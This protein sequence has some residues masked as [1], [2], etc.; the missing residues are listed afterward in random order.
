LK[1]RALPLLL[2]FVTIFIAGCNANVYLEHFVPKDADEF[3]REYIEAI[4]DGDFDAARTAINP[5]FV[6]P[7]I[8]ERFK[9]VREKFGGA[10][11]VSMKLVKF[12]NTYNF[13]NGTDIISSF[14]LYEIRTG[15][16]WFKADVVV[17]RGTERLYI[18]GF[19][20]EPMAGPFK[21]I[22]AFRLS[23]KSFYQYTLIPIS[24][25][26]FIFIIHTALLCLRVMKGEDMKWP[27]F[28]FILFGAGA[29]SM[30]WTTGELAWQLFT[31]QFLGSGIL[32]DGIHGPWI[33]STSMPVGAIFFYFKHSSWSKR[34]V[35]TAKKEADRKK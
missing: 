8:D 19:F 21:E 33:L 13:P 31:A 26:I 29:F 32:R 22:N 2:L 27:W 12:D 34:A 35:D 24:I 15:H 6:T 16:D 11:P 3:V 9:E 25:F 4:A 17:D 10:A 7:D 5:K 23:G 20:I 30:N 18:Y 28:V 1:N 14:L